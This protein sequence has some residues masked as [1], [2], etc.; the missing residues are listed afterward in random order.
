MW[1]K[2]RERL[3]HWRLTVNERHLCTFSP[4]TIVTPPLRWPAGSGIRPVT[5]NHSLSH[6]SQA[7]MWMC[8]HAQIHESDIS[9]KIHVQ[10]WLEHK[11]LC[12]CRAQYICVCCVSRHTMRMSE[13]ILVCYSDIPGG[14]EPA[15]LFSFARLPISLHEY[16]L[17]GSDIWFHPHSVGFSLSVSIFSLTVHVPAAYTFSKWGFTAFLCVISFTKCLYFS[18]CLTDKKETV[19]TSICALGIHEQNCHLFWLMQRNST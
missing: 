5:P 12:T 16:S 13:L 18:V 4:V 17:G 7:H 11:H 3:C 9:L 14:K 6:D 10:H 1:L 8:Q 15:R 19:Q 2:R